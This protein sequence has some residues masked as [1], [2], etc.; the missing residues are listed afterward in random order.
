MRLYI[1]IISLCLVHVSFSQIEK[2]G[3]DEYEFDVHKKLIKEL[4][5]PLTIKSIQKTQLDKALK[6]HIFTGNPIKDS[7][8]KLNLYGSYYYYK[9]DLINRLKVQLKLVIHYSDFLTKEQRN[10]YLYKV[11]GLYYNFK[12]YSI[13]IHFFKKSLK[14]ERDHTKLYNVHASLALCYLKTEYID[15]ALKH[16]KHSLIY[17]ERPID[18]IRALN[19]VG[20]ISAFN[21]DFISAEI[22]YKQALQVFQKNKNELDSIQYLIHHSRMGHLALLKGDMLIAKKEKSH[23]ENLGYFKKLKNKSNLKRELILLFSKI[24]LNNLQCDKTLSLLN[25]IDYLAYKDNKFRLEYLELKLRHAKNCG[26]RALLDNCFKSYLEEQNQL[27]LRE[28]DRSQMIDSIT[29]GLYNQQLGLV[30]KN[31]EL[32]KRSELNLETSNKRL[33]KLIWLSALFLIILMVYFITLFHK[34]KQKEKLVIL[35]Q[36]LLKEKQQTVLLNEKFTETQLKN[37]KLELI[38]LINETQKTSMILREVGIR[39]NDMIKKKKNINDDIIKLQHFIKLN[40]RK[41]ELK[42]VINE[43]ANELKPNFK[44]YLKRKYTNLT[45]NDVQ[46]LVLILIGL[47]NKEIAQF[48]NV[49]PTSVRTL[50]YRLKIKMNIP[51]SEDLNNYLKNI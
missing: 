30:N 24:T 8:I 1:F 19:S 7:I 17:A 40:S 29:S 50:K 34:Q 32:T 26:N 39:L 16:A 23:I 11:G 51:K 14:H 3:Y 6:E 2:N 4:Y 21:K 43:K 5:S 15:E 45:E 10:R 48:K 47:T 12:E 13:A 28:I 46:L 20:Y 41:D 49:E 33:S 38:Q 37:K 9:K 25:S 31:L 18:R 44:Y 36:N 22:K 42:K 35:K 27:K